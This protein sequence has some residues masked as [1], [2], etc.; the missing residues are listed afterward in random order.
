MGAWRTVLIETWPW[1]C[2]PF[3]FFPHGEAYTCWG[4]WPHPTPY[5][6][7]IEVRP[8][9]RWIE[10]G[11]SVVEELLHE[12]RLRSPGKWIFCTGLCCRDNDAQYA[13]KP[14][15]WSIIGDRQGSKPWSRIRGT[16]LSFFGPASAWIGALGWASWPSWAWKTKII[17]GT[18]AELFAVA[19]SNEHDHCNK[20]GTGFGREL[21]GL[22][23]SVHNEP[24]RVNEI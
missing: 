16:V 8:R 19:P 5:T 4:S 11:S 21:T 1:H 7:T 3:C 24:L 10:T 9:G 14:V 6:R 15:N 22:V 12:L 2:F 13:P 17:V 23:G 18:V 20:W